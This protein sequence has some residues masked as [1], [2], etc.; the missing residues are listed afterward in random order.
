[1]Q[2]ADKRQHPL[3]GE[4]LAVFPHLQEKPELKARRFRC[5]SSLP[6]P[7]SAGPQPAAR[8]PRRSTSFPATLC[9]LR[10][11]EI[12][13]RQ[14]KRSKHDT[15]LLLAVALTTL[16]PPNQG[17]SPRHAGGRGQP[18]AAGRGWGRACTSRW[19]AGEKT[20]RRPRAWTCLLP[21]ALLFVFRV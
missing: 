9:Q 21:A 5:R 12:F 15:P 10:H 19:A 8:A 1:M 18:P 4:G 3:G 11:A 17:R 6:S 16:T 7:A 13:S 14:G 2:T 20:P